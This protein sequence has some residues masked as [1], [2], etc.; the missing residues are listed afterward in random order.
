MKPSTFTPKLLRQRSFFR[1]LL[2]LFAIFLGL[3]ASQSVLA[4]STVATSN[5]SLTISQSGVTSPS[6]NYDTN[7][8]TAGPFVFNNKDFGTFNLASDTFILNGGTIT[9]NEDPADNFDQGELLFRVFPGTLATGTAPAFTSLALTNGGTSGGIRTFT[10]ST[11]AQNI[12]ASAVAG[13]ATGASNRFDVRFRV[14]DNSGGAQI[15]TTIRKS[16]FTSIGS[17]TPAT[18]IGG[19]PTNTQ[20]DVLINT[21]GTLTPNTTYTTSAFQGA[22]LGSYDINT[23]KLTLN[24]GDATTFESNGDIVQSVRLV[25]QI[26]KP[27]QPGTPTTVVFP[28][29]NIGL[30]Q[31]A[32]GPLSGGTSRTFGN[33]TALR[34]LI[35]GLANSGI[36]NYNIT[37]RFEA[38]VLTVGGTIYTVRDPANGGYTATFSTT[39]VPI[40]LLTWEGDVND[41]YFNPGNWDLNRIPDLT[42]N[43]L[44]P[45]YGSGTGRVAP[46]INAGVI[47]TATP[48]GFPG[49]VGGTVD[50]TASGPALARNVELG[51]STQALR[52]ITRLVKGRWKINGSFSNFFD[53][54]I[55]RQQ[56]TVEFSSPGNATISNGT[57][58]NVDISGGGTKTLTGVM[59]IA[60]SLNFLPNGGLLT[61]DV[62]QPS[63]N[64]VTLSNRSVDA[65][66]GAQLTGETDASPIPSYIRGFVRTQRT[67]VMANEMKNGMP[68]PRTFGNMGMTLYFTGTSNPGDI[69]VTRNTAESYTPLAGNPGAQTA[70]YGIRRI[71]GVRPGNSN[72]IVADLTFHY[73]DSELQNLGPAPSNGFILEQNL[74]L[75]LST[76]G[77]NQFGSLGRTSLDQVNNILTRDGVRTFATF[78]LGDLT[79]PLPV[80]LTGFDAKR[81]GVDAFVTW[82]TAS[83]QNSKGYNVQVSNDGKTYRTLAFV[84]SESPNSS[85]PKSYNFLDTEANKLGARYY[86]LEQVDL[87][88][89]STFYA[90]RI[91][92][93][94]GKVTSAGI[95]AYPN[96]YTDN[97]HLSLNSAVSGTGIVRVL[98]IAG[99]Q[100]AAHDLSISIGSNDLSIAKMGELKAGV[101]I[102]KVSLPSGETKSM[103]V[104]KQ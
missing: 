39:G 69:D 58:V 32:V 23:G 78:T 9:I 2:P 94:E 74:G 41:D 35:S 75:F 51:G 10:L 14:T 4:Q 72:G 97:V 43:V 36:G 45:D 76:S 83:E 87:S 68:D 56:T 7:T 62:S 59:T 77:G 85:T 61:T 73:L 65:P 18:N 37:V 104:V 89:K 8:A 81:M 71:F 19:A 86:R 17:P 99:R 29:S 24:G 101:Y 26:I 95:I 5:V 96:P 102:L 54:F 84:P 15:L 25:Y 34:N 79:N 80:T 30:Q 91:V 12:L 70:R 47:F 11:A 50:N 22:N 52:S 40:L 48:S 20:S 55:Q 98:D 60:V 49:A 42:T 103:K 38:D 44:V 53:S 13:S 92:T 31:S 100:V 63:S 6:G 28:T 46:N 16:V 57:F 88:G 67:D 3:G 66:D 82:E 64:Y 1:F 93:F 27:V 33:A 21:T 90:P